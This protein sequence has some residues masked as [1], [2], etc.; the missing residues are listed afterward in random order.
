MSASG[1]SGPLVFSPLTLLL[2]DTY[3]LFFI[4]TFS[5]CPFIIYIRKCFQMS[6][7]AKFLQTDTVLRKKWPDVQCSKKGSK[8]ASY[9]IKCC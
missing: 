6:A 4:E 3:F 1:P 8:K 7:P 5:R 9:K 2:V